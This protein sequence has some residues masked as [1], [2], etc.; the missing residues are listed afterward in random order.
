MSVADF[1][2]AALVLIGH[3]STVNDRSADSVY[4]HAAE[5]RRRHIF[6]EVLEAFWKQEPPLLDAASHA[7]ASRILFVPFLGPMSAP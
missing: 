1:S 7:R 4:Q 2:N 5:L 6:G 3:G